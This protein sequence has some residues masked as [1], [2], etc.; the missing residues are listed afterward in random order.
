MVYDDDRSGS[1]YGIMLDEIVRDPNYSCE[2]YGES[3]GG[4]LMMD[5]GGVSV[6][7]T[8]GAV[9]DDAPWVA[10][11]DTEGEFITW[12]SPFN[13]RNRLKDICMAYGNEVT[14]DYIYCSLCLIVRVAPA[15]DRM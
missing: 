5:M 10:D 8:Q 2:R 14:A 7:K 4:V 13:E 6:N 9:P 3:Y 15:S 12:I 1:E 11:Y